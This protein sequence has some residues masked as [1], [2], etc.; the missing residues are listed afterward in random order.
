MHHNELSFVNIKTGEL[1]HSMQ[2]GEDYLNRY[3]APYLHVLRSDVHDILAQE[4][5]RRSPNGCELNACAS[6]YT[7]TE[8]DITLHTS[9]A[10]SFTGD[11]LIG[12]DG[13]KSTVK[14][15]LVGAKKRHF[16]GQRSVAW[17]GASEPLAG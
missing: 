3:G 11:C 6:S 15:Q 8:S 16:Y 9:D 10:R 2:W 5:M 7:A 4:L 12:A 13:I 14:T 17:R 1:L